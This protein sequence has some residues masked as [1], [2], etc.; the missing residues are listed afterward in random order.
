MTAMTELP[1]KF[2]PKKT[3]YNYQEDAVDFIKDKEYGGIF[4]EQGLGK[5]KIAIDIILYWLRNNILDRVILVAKKGLVN[6][7]Q[8][9]LMNHSYLKARVISNDIRENRKAF[10]SQTNVIIAH[11]ETFKLEY[12]RI[13]DLAEDSRVGIILDEATK[14]K[15]PEA[16][17]SII[18]HQLAPSFKK[19]LIMTG[20]PIANR[21]YDIWSQIYFLDQGNALGDNFQDFKKKYDIDKKLGNGGYDTAIS[22][23]ASSASLSKS[24]DR[25]NEFENALVE[26]QTKLVPFTIRENKESE[27][28][29][30]PQK[31]F[32]NVLCDWEDEQESLYR[33]YIIDFGAMINKGGIEVSDD[34]E[35]II[36]RLLRLVQIASNPKL[37]DENYNKIPG[38]ETI[39]NALI[40]KIVSQKEKVIVWS[41][42]TANIDYFYKKFTRFNPVKIHGKISIEDRNRAVDNFLLNQD[43]SILFATPGAAKE[44][45]TLTVANHAIFFDRGFSLDDYLQ[46]QD[47]IH[48]VSQVKDCYIYNLMMKDSIDMWIDELLGMKKYAAKL[49]QGDINIQEY[50]SHVNYSFVEILKGILNGHK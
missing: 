34:S 43:C 27:H 31:I 35:E 38:K 7:W 6:N 3:A 21:P 37:V 11:Y 2:T 22:N 41:N 24:S 1:N 42:F 12:K 5:S 8:R 17:L 29:K 23:S 44:G 30:L 10:V 28:V 14:I 33:K 9:E 20:T 36:K 32:D 47:R 18:F 48:R 16:A 39:L 19:R 13:K 46:A 26:L 4:H 50:K 40:E 25:Q 45:L 49:A 15:N